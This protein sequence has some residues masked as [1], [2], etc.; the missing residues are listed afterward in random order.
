MLVYKGQTLY[1]GL[2]ENGVT[3]AEGLEMPGSAELSPSQ[4]LQLFL[5]RRQWG[6]RMVAGSPG[7][8]GHEIHFRRLPVKPGERTMDICISK[9]EHKTTGRTVHGLTQGIYDLINQPDVRAQG[10]FIPLTTSC[11]KSDY[12]RLVLTR[13]EDPV[14]VAWGP[15]ERFSVPN[16]YDWSLYAS[17]DN[18]YGMLQPFL[19]IENCIG[20]EY[21]G[22]GLKMKVRGRANATEYTAIFKSRGTDLVYGNLQG[23]KFSVDTEW[24]MD[25]LDRYVVQCKCNPNIMLDLVKTAHTDPGYKKL[26]SRNKGWSNDGKWKNDVTGATCKFRFVSFV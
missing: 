18:D 9:S 20:L 14:G 6:V 12:M 22:G 3:A 11:R 7:D 25:N 21:N 4:L 8:D 5:H 23:V 26:D 2:W 17:N 24:V 13:D 15:E 19:T 10:V 16:D 1:T